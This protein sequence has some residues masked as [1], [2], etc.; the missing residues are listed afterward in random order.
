LALSL[1]LRSWLLILPM[2]SV[3]IICPRV[4]GPWA[5]RGR[6]GI[7]M[8]DVALAAPRQQRASRRRQLDGSH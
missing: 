8:I 1:E 3:Q 7:S 4:I 5:L 6:R 2:A